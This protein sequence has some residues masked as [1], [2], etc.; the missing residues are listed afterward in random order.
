M[1]IYYSKL[2]NEIN[3]GS[4]I[5][6]IAQENREKHS[7][8]L[9]N[10]VFKPVQKLYRNKNKN[11]LLIVSHHGKLKKLLNLK[12]EEKTG[13]ANCACLK[14]SNPEPDSKIEVIFGGFPDKDAYQYLKT[15]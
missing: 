8:H 11:K 14:I 12:T 4:I 2:F 5:Y 13:I 1:S 3:Q 6:Y 7:L 9:E 15:G 10:R